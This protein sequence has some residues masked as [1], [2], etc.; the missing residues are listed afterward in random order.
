MEENFL[1]TVSP[2]IYS[3]EKYIEEAKYY[4]NKYKDKIKINIGLEVD[5]L[6]GYEEFTTKMLDIYEMY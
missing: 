6:E 3:I 2:S 1:D 4:K 5:Y